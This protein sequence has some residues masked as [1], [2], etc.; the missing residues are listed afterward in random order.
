MPTRAFEFGYPLRTRSVGVHVKPWGLAPFLPM[1]AAELCVV[2]VLFGVPPLR[3]FITG[4]MHSLFAR[5][6]TTYAVSTAASATLVQ[7][8]TNK[9]T[10]SDH[11]T[12]RVR[13]SGST[14]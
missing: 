4:R 3:R 1:P 2:V 10:Q 12:R 11:H 13:Q 6:G 8:P 14:P 5:A 7:P 9:P